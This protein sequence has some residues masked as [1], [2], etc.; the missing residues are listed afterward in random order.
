MALLQ[1]AY[2]GA[3]PLFRNTSFFDG[4]NGV[5]INA[6]SIVTITANSSAHTKGAWS[7]LIASTSAQASFIIIDAGDVSTSATN[8]ATLLDIGTGAS[9]SETALIENV[10][11]GSAI[12]SAIRAPFAFGVPI[13]IPSGVR[14]SARIQ[15]VVT[16]GKTATIRIFTFDLGDY[17]AAPTSV[18]VIGTDTATSTG[19]AMSGASGTWTQVIASTTRAYRAVVA[20]PSASDATVAGITIQFTVGKGAAASETEIGRVLG[21][22]SDIETAGMGVLP[23]LIPASVAS[24]TRLA[25]RHDV[26]TGVS[27][28]YDI[29]LI[30]IP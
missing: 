4:A 14:L 30:G 2:L 5:P 1:K 28:P 11:I 29:T 17:A 20:V 16:G 13:Q 7:Q 10:A 9:G 25:V 27:G 24:G 19:T 23:T 21:Q 6:S 3:T 22:F 12:R 26:A 8:T 18:D 15:S